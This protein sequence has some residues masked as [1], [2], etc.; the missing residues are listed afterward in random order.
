MEMR[1]RAC[2][3]KKNPET[4]PHISD[5]KRLQIAIKRACR[6]CVP[7]KSKKENTVTRRKV[8]QRKRDLKIVYNL[9]YVK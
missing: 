2:V 9:H 7:G 3:G 8:T 1:G 4:A 5:N 6:V